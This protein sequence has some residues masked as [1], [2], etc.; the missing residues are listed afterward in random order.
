MRSLLAPEYREQFDEYLA[1]IRRDGFSEGSMMLLTR[2]GE[3]RIWEYHNTLRTDCGSEPIVR[4]MAH[5]V[6][7]RS[8]AEAALRLSEQRFRVALANSSVIVCNQDRE[9]KYTWISGAALPRMEPQQYLGRNDAEILAGEEGARLTAIKQ[10]VLEGGDPAR[11]EVSVTLHGEKRYFDLTVEALLDRR[12]AV[13]GVTCAAVEITPLKRALA[14][15][16]ELIAELQN[17]LEKNEYLATHDAL[18]G[19]ANRRLL[20]DR[21]GQALA[22]AS[23]Q[24]GKVAILALD[25]DGF[26]NVNDTLGHNVGDLVLTSVVQ[27]IRARL[28]ASD[29]LSRSGGDEFT[30]LAEVADKRGAQ[31]VAC[32]LQTV[33]TSPFEVE[34]KVVFLGA[35]IGVALYPDNG[36]TAD[37]VL[38]AADKSMYVAKDVNKGRLPA[39]KVDGRRLG[40]NPK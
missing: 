8:R 5:D 24:N 36:S 2:G 39:A 25:L 19:V 13:A 35:S 23:R 14:E 31:V 16:E 21:L 7:E 20:A 17:A 6:T 37:E 15:R 33:F 26:K 29:T 4:G 3:R 30:V 27:R 10:S 1:Q 38:T 12:G 11:S 22:R 34:G 18:T 28:R 40:S 32:A 9:L